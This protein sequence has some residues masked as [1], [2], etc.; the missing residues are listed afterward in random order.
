MLILKLL[1]RLTL[2]SALAI[3]TAIAPLSIHGGPS[4]EDIPFVVPFEEPP[5]PDTWL[6]AQPYGNT[7]SAYR[8]RDVIYGRSQ[9]IH[10][11]VD[12]SARCGTEIVAIA[13]GV[14]FAVDNLNFGSAPHNLIIDHLLPVA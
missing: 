1:S 11:G 8:Q 4:D 14:V 3:V 7:I 6:M 12:F 9:G 2:F 5:G 10:F 13:D